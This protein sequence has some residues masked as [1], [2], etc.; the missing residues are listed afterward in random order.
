MR[1]DYEDNG[2]EALDHPI[3]SEF[4]RRSRID[5]TL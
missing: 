5:R 3:V 4:Y 2:E 1:I